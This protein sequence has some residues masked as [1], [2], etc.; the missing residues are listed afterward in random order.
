MT[1][2]YIFLEYNFLSCITRKKVVLYGIKSNKVLNTFV[3][4]IVNESV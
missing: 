3:V 2:C 1:A 4:T